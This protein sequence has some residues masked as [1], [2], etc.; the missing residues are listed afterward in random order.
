[1]PTRP[2][3]TR[4]EDDLKLFPDM[5]HKVG[6]VL[7]FLALVAFPFVASSQWMTVALV[8]EVSVV[9]AVGLMIL[10]GFTG[11]IS[12]GHAAF[13]AI[14]AYTAAVLGN[15]F[16]LPFWLIMPIAGLLAAAVG[17]AVGPFAL[18]L[19]GLYLAIVTLGLL[20]LVNHVLFSFPEYTRGVSGISV[21]V[22]V[23]F[24]AP[25]AGNA[26]LSFSETTYLGGIAF[27]FERKLYVIRRL[28]E[29]QQVHVHVV[30][31]EGQRLRRH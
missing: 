26:W 30:D 16:Q 27:A 4:Y 13:M 29:K 23:G 10:T 6:L 24:G 18:R 11:Q 1:M 31:R 17:L 14:G 2:L 7:G 15:E 19:R 3:V 28:V 8:A 21:P 25:P 20:F 12:L 22:Y 9:G 5:W